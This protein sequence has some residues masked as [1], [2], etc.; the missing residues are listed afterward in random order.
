MS[1]RDGHLGRGRRRVEGPA[2]AGR[3]GLEGGLV[4][5]VA[6]ELCVEGGLGRCCPI[7]EKGCPRV[8]GGQA[9]DGGVEAVEGEAG[10]RECRPARR[11]GRRH[12]LAGRL[13]GGEGLSAGPEVGHGLVGGGTGRLRLGAQTGE[14]REAGDGVGAEGGRREL[15]GA[16]IGEGRV[17]VGECER[18]TGGQDGLELP[19]RLLRAAVPRVHPGE[20]VPQAEVV[21]IRH[22][23]GLELGDAVGLERPPR[24][25]GG[26]DRVELR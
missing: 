10:C 15:G 14:C 3:E 13:R 2:L 5:L 4:R 17:R 1:R 21:G 11:I 18:E 8:L 9:R 25:S 16:D 20:L 22:D 12:A 24:P 7:G 19:R 6:G 26:K 23:A